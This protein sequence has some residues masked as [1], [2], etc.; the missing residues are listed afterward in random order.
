MD[1]GCGLVD[2]GGRCLMGIVWLLMGG[3]L[4]VVSR[5][6]MMDHGWRGRMDDA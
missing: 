3:R 1:D 5:G 4:R 6:W 2:D